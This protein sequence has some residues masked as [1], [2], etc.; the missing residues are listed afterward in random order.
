MEFHCW[1]LKSKIDSSLIFIGWV[2]EM[3][4][5]FDW[6]DISPHRQ[7]Q[8]A[9][10]EL[11]GLAQ[12]YWES[13]EQ[14]V[15]WKYERP[16]TSWADIRV[17]LRKK[18]VPRHY[19]IWLLEQYDAVCHGSFSITDYITRFDNLRMRCGVR[20]SPNMTITRFKEG[21]RPERQE[22]LR[23]YNIATL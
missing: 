16:V 21:L 2:Q 3:D 11:L 7:V 6:Y 14:E 8:F 23:F 19:Q 5:Y 17:R 18:Y 1:L 4:Q 13:V 20:E 12:L 10:M 22:K 9:M 15:Y